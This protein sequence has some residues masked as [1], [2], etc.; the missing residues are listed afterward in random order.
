MN[1]IGILINMKIS[2]DFNVK[3]LKMAGRLSAY[4]PKG[5]KNDSAPFIIERNEVK[6]R[7]GNTWRTSK[8]SNFSAKDYKKPL[9]VI[10]QEN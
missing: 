3:P 9:N 4:T 5:Q 1:L 6:M 8:V 10:D 2:D 7:E